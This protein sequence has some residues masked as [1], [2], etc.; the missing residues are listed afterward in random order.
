MKHLESTNEELWNSLGENN[1]A[2]GSLQRM[3]VE[4][5]IAVEFPGDENRTKRI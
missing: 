4:S 1:K 5:K 2:D 3:Y